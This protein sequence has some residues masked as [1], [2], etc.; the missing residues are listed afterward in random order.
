MNTLPPTHQTTINTTLLE[1]VRAGTGAP[2]IVLV[3][4][5]GGPIEGW[6]RVWPLI[7]GLSTVFAYN[8]PGLG[9][10]GKPTE[11]QTGA[12]VVATLRALLAAVGLQPPYLLVGHSLGGLSVNLFARTHPA[13]VAGVVLLEATAPE[14]VAAM[15]T[16]EH[17]IQRGLRRLLNAISPEDPLNETTN[18]AQTVAQLAAAGPFPDV[19]L[20]VVTGGSPAFPWLTPLPAREARASHQCMLAALSPQGQQIIA[21]RSGHFPQ[22]T[23]PEVVAAAVQ[24]V[25]DLSRTQRQ[26]SVETEA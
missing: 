24:V 13:E 17:A 16:H 11:A 5:A 19:P 2:P 10:S 14:D 25:L 23:E 20:V 6:Y 9:K 4:G 8:R 7:E 21:A 1:Y 12:V 18:V 15:A 22:F 3:N 26:L